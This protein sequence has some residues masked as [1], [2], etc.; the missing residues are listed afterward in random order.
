MLT[1]AGSGTTIDRHTHRVGVHGE[2]V[3][4]TNEVDG[5][6]D[7]MSGEGTIEQRGLLTR[8]ESFTPLPGVPR[9]SG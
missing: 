6:D 5:L 4:A 1:G 9:V 8:T 7:R 2:G 3:R